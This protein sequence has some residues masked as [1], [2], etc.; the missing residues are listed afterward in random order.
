MS[1]PAPRQGSIT[2]D[3]D[4]IVIRIPIEDAHGLRVALQPIRAG[5]TTS[6]ST[7]SIRDRLDR[8]LAR[9]LA[10]K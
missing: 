8:G 5:E 2:R 7:Q 4:D 9:A 10:R 6:N 1:D 3:G